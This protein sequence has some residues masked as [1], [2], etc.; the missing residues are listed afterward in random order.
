MI[1]DKETADN[2]KK[3]AQV[4]QSEEEAKGLADLPQIESN[5][6]SNILKITLA[7]MPPL[8]TAKLRAYCS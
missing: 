1:I 7:N 6:T 8:C 4:A 3:S 2:E 5:F